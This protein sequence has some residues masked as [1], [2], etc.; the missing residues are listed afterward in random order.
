MSTEV[1]QANKPINLASPVIISGAVAMLGLG[2]WLVMSGPDVSAADAKAECLSLATE[3]M[4]TGRDVR[5]MDTWT[6]KGK[7]VVELG[8]FSDRNSKSYTARVCVVGEG[9]VQRARYGRALDSAHR[10]SPVAWAVYQ[11]E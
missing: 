4:R 5:V 11:T 7:R 1:Q 2:A 10:H 8:Y 3:N 6:K 9:R